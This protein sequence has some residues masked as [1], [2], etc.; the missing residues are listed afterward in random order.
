MPHAWAVFKVGTGEVSSQVFAGKRRG[1]PP[2]P[3]KESTKQMTHI[4]L[5]PARD[6]SLLSLFCPEREFL[7]FRGIS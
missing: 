3:R 6:H 5:M 2:S 7:G 1:S 4:F